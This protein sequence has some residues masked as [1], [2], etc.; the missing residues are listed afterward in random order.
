MGIRDRSAPAGIPVAAPLRFY[1]QKSEDAPL[2]QQS[3]QSRARQSQGFTLV[4]LMAVMVVIGVLATFAVPGITG[5]VNNSRLSGQASEL[6]ATLQLARSEA[7]RRNVPVEVCA[8]SYT[9]RDV[10]K[11]QVL[12]SHCAAASVTSN[13]QSSPS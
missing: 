4:E 8:V 13:P 11:R 12:A 2:L 7:V 9:H 1:G 6:A 3:F 5:M 10:Y